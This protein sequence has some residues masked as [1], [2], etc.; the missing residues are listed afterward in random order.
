MAWLDHCWALAAAL[1]LFPPFLLRPCATGAE[2]CAAPTLPDRCH[3]Y[4]T[5][6]PWG[7]RRLC[8]HEVCA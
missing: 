2:R 1:L 7:M 6:S 4:N 5:A 3:T 8:A